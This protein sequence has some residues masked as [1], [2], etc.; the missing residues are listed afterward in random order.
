[1][2]SF[3]EG[4]RP[5]DGGSHPG[6]TEY[7]RLYNPQLEDTTVEI[8]ISY[9]GNPG[10]ETFRRVLPARRVTEFNIDQFITGDRRTV[11]SYFT[12]T[13]KGASPIV[14][15][16]GHYDRFFPGAFGM[17]GTPMGISTPIS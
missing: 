9:A 3:G 10:S 13:V 2:W 7:L 8:T 14:A 15:Y 4:F 11:T 16:F 17:L 6:V 12:T 5:R 1:M